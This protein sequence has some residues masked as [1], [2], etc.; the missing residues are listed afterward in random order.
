M[1]KINETLNGKVYESAKDIAEAFEIP[2]NK[3]YSFT[4]RKLHGDKMVNA[5]NQYKEESHNAKPLK[6]EITVL[7]IQAESITELANLLKLR[8][9]YIYNLRYKY[10][11]ESEF[12]QNLEARLSKKFA[13]SKASM[14][15]KSLWKD[16]KLSDKTFPNVKSIIDEYN[17]PQPYVSL[18]LE[19]SKSANEFA[20]KVRDYA[21]NNNIIPKSNGVTKSTVKYE[22]PQNEN[23]K[24]NNPIDELHNPSIQK[25]GALSN[26][27]IQVISE[28]TGQKF[29]ISAFESAYDKGI[30]LKL[31]QFIKSNADEKS[32]SQQAKLQAE[33]QDLKKSESSEIENLK[34]EN[35]KLAE[36]LQ[37]LTSD[38][39]IRKTND[40]KQRENLNH[41]LEAISDKLSDQKKHWWQKL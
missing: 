12:L 29:D 41:I 14:R 13:L 40:A 19:S 3:V 6:K 26:L 24:S 38:F 20:Q 1:P 28:Y 22:T 10:K 31:S 21:N 9:G 2:I 16:I 25:I 5:I 27:L 32:L 34:S 18:W 11:D 4:S 30:D 8:P 17:I 37:K 7:G 15:K 39:N 33:L 35:E 36:Q 23:V